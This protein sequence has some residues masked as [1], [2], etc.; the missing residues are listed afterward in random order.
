MT[1]EISIRLNEKL[2]A[3]VDQLAALTGRRPAWLIRR[4]ID[5]YIEEELRDARDIA[6]VLA[7][8]DSGTAVL[9][10]HE[11]VMAEMDQLLREKLGDGE[12]DRLMEAEK[13]KELTKSKGKH[14][15]YE[16]DPVRESVR[17]LRVRHGARR[18]E[19]L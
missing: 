16:I 19:D 1:K 10:P 14:A 13:S 11:E 15:S 5:D 4:M 12:F 9:I 2:A 18:P 8:I 7:D 6:E 17:I 3:K